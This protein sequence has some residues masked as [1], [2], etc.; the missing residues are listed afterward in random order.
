MFYSIVT[1]V[2]FACLLAEPSS[3]KIL[4]S[5]ELD[6]SYK[7]MSSKTNYAVIVNSESFSDYKIPS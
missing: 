3:Q 4:T 6:T 1:T 7:L 2:F 5:C